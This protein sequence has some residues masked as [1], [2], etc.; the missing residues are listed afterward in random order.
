VR[1]DMPCPIFNPSPIVVIT[2]FI[3][4]LV[5]GALM[6]DLPDLISV[7]AALASYCRLLY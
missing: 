7:S 3:N 4:I 1:C 5:I 2:I 6:L